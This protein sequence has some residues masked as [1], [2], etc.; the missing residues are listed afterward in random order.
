MKNLILAFAVFFTA[1]LASAQT[2]KNKI[3]TEDLQLADDI[4]MNMRFTLAP[5]MLSQSNRELGYAV[6]F[7]VT[8]NFMVGPQL[9][10]FKYSGKYF[11]VDAYAL[12]VNTTYSL[13]ENFSNGLFISTGAKIY[14]YNSSQMSDEFPGESGNVR[15]AILP[16]QNI[17]LS[18]MYGYKWFFSEGFNVRLSAGLQYNSNDSLTEVSSNYNAVNEGRVISS[19]RG[20]KVNFDSDL[21]I[22]LTY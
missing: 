6:D 4:T 16:E 8:E 5:M 13:N 12:G 9:S 21:S 1:Q 22:G 17:N 19:M 18:I 20:S 2:N 3:S 14:S 15:D 10:Y 7:A 11:N